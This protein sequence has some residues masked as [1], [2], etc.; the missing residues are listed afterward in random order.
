MNPLIAETHK[1]TIQNIA[2]A[3]DA[4]MV[5]LASTDSNLCRLLSPLQAAIEHLCSKTKGVV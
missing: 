3:F 4:V 1:D 5:L 2:E